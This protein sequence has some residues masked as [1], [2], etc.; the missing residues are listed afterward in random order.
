MPR[1]R[2]ALARLAGSLTAAATVAAA[3]LVAVHA[4]AATTGCRVNYAVTNQWQGGFGA[5]V[6][7]TNLGDPVTGWTLIWSYAAGQTVAQ[8]WN[9]TVSQSGAQVSAVNVG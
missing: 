2:T 8:A 7:I 6:T 1:S 9:A 5:N 4:D 3:V